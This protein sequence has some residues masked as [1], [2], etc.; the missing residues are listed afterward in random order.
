MLHLDP[1]TI[2]LAERLAAARGLFVDQAVKQAIEDSAQAAGIAERRRRR[3]SVQEI[4]AVG[5][6]IAAMPLL[7]ARTPRDIMDDLNA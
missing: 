3:Q 2:A 5:A 7:D 6:E 1:E 4:L